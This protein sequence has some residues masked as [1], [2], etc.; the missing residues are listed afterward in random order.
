MADSEYDEIFI[1][2]DEA[3]MGDG[4]VFGEYFSP[5]YD[6]RRLIDERVLS[7]EDIK[8][9][10]KIPTSTRINHFE[11]HNFALES[12]RL[13]AI[14]SGL[15]TTMHCHRYGI[16]KVGMTKMQLGTYQSHQACSKCSKCPFFPCSHVAQHTI[17]L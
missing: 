14:L 12:L 4:T 8:K 17:V 9:M 3:M 16:Q 13:N 7:F 15:N 11:L 10:K 1:S 6:V 2:P 5:C